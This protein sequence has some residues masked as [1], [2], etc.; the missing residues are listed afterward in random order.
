[1]KTVFSSQNSKQ[2][3]FLPSS[4]VYLNIAYVWIVWK[5]VFLFNI[6]A[7]TSL[8]TNNGDARV[9]LASGFKGKIRSQQNK[10][11]SGAAACVLRLPGKPLYSAVPKAK[12]CIFKCEPDPVDRQEATLCFIK[13]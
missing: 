9:A 1:M 12:R 7:I 13:I 4:R 3:I 5:S 6:I 8:S 2:I 10:Q 11:K